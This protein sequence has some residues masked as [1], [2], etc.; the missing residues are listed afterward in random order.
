MVL[1]SKHSTMHGQPP[2]TKNYLAPHVR[3]AEVG[4][5]CSK[6][7]VFKV[8]AMDI[9]ITKVTNMNVSLAPCFKTNFD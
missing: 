4:E 3:I 6:S 1:L 7:L 2:P 9:C 8:W 5:A